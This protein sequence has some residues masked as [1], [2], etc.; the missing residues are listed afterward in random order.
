MPR[1]LA[2]V[3]AVLL[4][5]GV[6]GLA[7]HEDPAPER[8]IEPTT[9]EVLPTTSTAPGTPP[10]TATTTTS[11]PPATAELVDLVAE[12]QAFVERERGLKFKD[13]VKVTL[14]DDEAFRQR[15]ADETKVDKEEIAK[16][17]RVL[18]ALDLIEPGVD[19][20]KAQQ[21]LLGGAV[22]GFYDLEAKELFVRGAD[23]S[24]AVRQT[25]VHELVHALQDQH[26]DVHRPEL[27]KQED[28]AEQVFTGL[29]EGDAV[30]IERM[31]T[32][33]MSKKDR[34]R[35]AKEQMAHVGDLSDVPPILLQSLVFPYEFG[36]PFVQ[37]LVREGGQA[38]LD[39]AFAAPPTTSEHLLHP[40][41]YLRGEGAAPVAE[42]PAEGTVIDQGVFGEFGFRQQLQQDIEPSEVL[43]A[44]AGWGGDRYIAWDE[45]SRTC[46]R[47]DVVMDTPRDAEE[48]RS[49]LQAWAKEHDDATVTGTSPIRFTSCGT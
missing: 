31:Y 33:T 23:I 32:A 12:L 42:P 38:R 15:I 2:V 14:L 29:V 27:G 41:T 19:L 39:A 49:A 26:F 37:A 11:V 3:V 13:P 44:A 45:G 34:E 18:R 40:D 48:I 5:A 7:V 22:V 46:V 21:A 43:R 20:E 9:V 10:D 24:P 4:V 25:L 36:P 17:T 47:V 6:A 16:I 28:E 8:A 35:A 1:L 30:R